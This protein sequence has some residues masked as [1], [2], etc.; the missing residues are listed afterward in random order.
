MN[1]NSYQTVKEH[2][3]NI[4]GKIEAPLPINTITEEVANLKKAIDVIGTEMFA[5][6]LSIKQ[7]DNL[8]E[9]DWQRLSRELETH[10]DVKM[11]CGILIQ[12]DEQQERDTTWW[13]AINK[14]KSKNYYWDRYSNYLSKSMPPEVIKTIDVD[15]DIVMNNIEDP[16]FES[17]SRYGMVVGHVQ[18]GKTGNYSALACKAADA[19]YK[20]IVVIAG[21]INNLRNQT[22]ERLNESFIGQT[23]GVQVG[24]GKGNTSKET[25]PLSLT[26]IERD[27]NKHDADRLSQGLNFDNINVPILL[28]IKKNTRTFESVIDW[29]EKQYK[30]KVPDHAM[31]V[32]DDESDYASINTKE[33][34]DPTA[35][36]K[37]IRKLLGLFQKSAYVAYTATPYANIFIDHKAENNDYGKDLFPKDFIYALD[38]PTNY[39]GARKIF[40]ETENAHLVAIN[41][42][43]DHIPTNHKKDFRIEQL[44]DSLQDAIRLFLL[45]ISI[46]SLRGQGNKHNSMLIHATRFTDVHKLL[47]KLVEDYLKAIKKE[48]VSFGKLPDSLAQSQLIQDIKSTFERHLS[49]IEFN[50]QE[51]LNELTEKIETVIVREVHQ[52]TS[53]PLE[54]RKDIVTNAIVIGGT[55]LSRGFTLEGLSISYFLRNTVFYDTLMQM[56]RWFGYRPGYEDLCRIFMPAQR[57]TDFADIIKATEELFDDFKLMAENKKTPNDFGLAVQE[58]PESAL[59][60]TAR[61]KQKNVREFFYSMRLD[62]TLKE[63]SYLRSNADDIQHNINSVKKIISKLGVPISKGGSYIW[64][65]ID[66]QEILNFFKDF[67]LYDNDRYGLTSRMPIAFIAQYAEERNTEWDIALYNGTGEVFKHN[68]LEVRKEKRQLELKAGYYEVLNRQVSSGNAEALSIENDLT[69][70]RVGNNRR[71]TRKEMERPLLMLHIIEQKF[72]DDQIERPIPVG[73]IAAF[74]VSFPGSVLSKEDTVKIKINTVYYQNLIDELELENELDD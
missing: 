47:G 59:Q 57:I 54:Y 40:I 7:F 65:S 69:R 4:L 43:S 20:F 38:A 17:F 23:K 26:T 56:G 22:Q 66:K 55:S 12:G 25:M 52:K 9:T 58:N 68:N 16:A 53:V 42:F 73:E 48:I 21:G 41:D 64:R 5:K 18:S 49:K 36:N 62:G 67:R 3:F 11:E 72:P 29:L 1:T 10:F 2:L 31:L 60:I 27:F 14:Q 33:E 39:F 50:W 51:I 35:I 71:E 19:G 8:D 70:Q 24:A 63:T 61:N 13:T 37:S 46:R 74:G 6:F 45:N 44:P 34:E 28:V 30:N 32:I 15:T